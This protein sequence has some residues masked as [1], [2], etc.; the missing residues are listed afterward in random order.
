MTRN[1][2]MR[3]HLSLL[4]AI[5]V[6]LQGCAADYQPAQT[7]GG[8]P[9]SGYKD[10]R[11]DANTATVTFDGN[12]FT[13]PST[14]RS[15][16]LYRCAEVTIENGYNYFVIL[17]T[18]TSATNVNVNTK[19]VNHYSTIP[20]KGYPVVYRTEDYRSYSRT[21]SAARNYASPDQSN[22]H[23]V[24]AVIKMFQGQKP[25]NLPRAFDAK[26]ILGHLGSEAD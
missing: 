8:F 15:Y 23:T 14:L 4:V 16:L 2:K 26:D 24:T 25:G 22:I 5:S 1:S 3:L 18:N 13:S 9:L 10:A 19:D 6:A 20:P 21:P 12:R 17:S 7:L 11:I